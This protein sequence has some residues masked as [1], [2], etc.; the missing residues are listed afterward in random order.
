MS[1]SNLFLWDDELECNISTESM[2][3]SGCNYSEV[4]KDLGC[5]VKDLKARRKEKM[6]MKLKSERKKNCIS[7]C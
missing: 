2:H 3:S 6:K 7:C 1:S 4:M 5:I